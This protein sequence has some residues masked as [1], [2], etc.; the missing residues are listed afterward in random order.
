M[1]QKWI[2]LVSNLPII[3]LL[4]IL[5]SSCAAFDTND[6]I[7]TMEYRSI[8]VCIVDQK[9]HPVD[10]V[11]ATITMVGNGKIYYWDLQDIN[12][13]GLYY[14]MTDSYTR[15]FSTTPDTLKLLAE[16]REAKTSAIFLISTDEC[17]CH[18]QK[19]SGPDTLRLEL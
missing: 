19:N 6:C 1:L 18:I 11:A 9:N 2:V 3:I 15:D 4:S 14:I 13:V 12:H 17:H 8:Q 16:K 5:V 10:S 7:C